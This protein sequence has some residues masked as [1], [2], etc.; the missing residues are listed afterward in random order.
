MKRATMKRVD[1]AMTQERPFKNVP[2][3]KLKFALGVGEA[4]L[5]QIWDKRNPLYKRC[6]TQVRKMREELARR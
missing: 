5:S 4:G 1:A 6:E 3:D 2:T